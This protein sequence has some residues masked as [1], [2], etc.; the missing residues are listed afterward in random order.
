MLCL[1]WTMDIAISSYTPVQGNEGSNPSTKLNSVHKKK[2]GIIMV[3]TTIFLEVKIILAIL[4]S[5][6]TNGNVLV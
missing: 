2:G 1:K 3:K 5:L 4:I 6:S